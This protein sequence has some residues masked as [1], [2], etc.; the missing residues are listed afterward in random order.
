MSG[1]EELSK[2]P[3][4][5]A[6]DIR[7]TPWWW[8]R[9][10]SFSGPVVYESST[11]CRPCVNASSN[12]D[13]NSD[14]SGAL[15]DRSNGGTPSKQRIKSQRSVLYYQLLLL[16]S[17]NFPIN[18]LW[19]SL[20]S[21]S[22]FT[23]RFHFTANRSSVWSLLFR[24]HSLHLFHAE[25]PHLCSVIVSL[26]VIKHIVFLEHWFSVHCLHWVNCYEV[27]SIAV[28]LIVESALVTALIE[29]AL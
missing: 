24:P 19:K 14:T 15:H 10:Q 2:F 3:V 22:S 25:I 1:Y 12:G 18:L 29:L 5:M 7:F 9:Q 11:L 27:A 8:A 21:F 6:L 23:P 4:C 13:A 20:I 17:H 28:M 26:T 16:Y